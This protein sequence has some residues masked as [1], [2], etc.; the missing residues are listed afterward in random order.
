[1]EVE[2][3]PQS[4]W[5]RLK[6]AD[7]P[8]VMYGM[9]DGAE[10]IM[11][12]FEQFGI[13]PAEFMAS[14]EF[15]RGHSFLGYQVKK[16]SEIEEK[17]KD[18]IIVVCFGSSLPDVMDKLCSLAEKYELYAPDVP[19]VGEGLF[20]RDYISANEKKINKVYKLLSDDKSR[21]VFDSIVNYKISGNIS[22]LKE[23]ETS[24]DEAFSLL[25]I[26]FNE[27]YVDLGAYNGDTID[28]FLRLTGKRFN[29]IYA[30][31][32]DFRNFG[33]MVR[34]NYALGRGIFHPINAAAWS[35][36]T[37][38]EFRRSGGRNSSVS[39]KYGRGTIVKVNGI[40]TD[41]ML[42]G[43]IP[44]LIKLDVEGCEREAL[45][46]ARKSITQHKPKLILSA[47]HRTEDLLDLPLL[48]KEMNS[49]YKLYLR[50]HPYIPAWDTNFYCI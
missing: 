43:K 29:E 30:V 37:E 46:G 5:Q 47:Y 36:N 17:Y 45:E 18:F 1:M 31:E 11:S 13:K 24:E 19:V 49:G 27:T 50:H 48:I 12:V 33:R 44:T 2:N 26:G 34:R 4:V 22:Y 21:E 25:D 38:L 32:P 3:L 6:T 8:I 23:C 39:T 14:D 16:L 40:S 7:K 28:K 35:E 15:V 41:A 10:K 20:D 42:G 9:G